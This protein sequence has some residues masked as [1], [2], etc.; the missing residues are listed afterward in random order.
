MPQFYRL[1]HRARAASVS[2][3]TSSAVEMRSR[4]L[5]STALELTFN[6]IYSNQQLSIV[7]SSVVEMCSRLLFSTALEMK[8]VFDCHIERSRDVFAL[9]VLYCARTDNYKIMLNLIQHLSIL[10]DKRLRG[11]PSIKESKTT[12][13]CSN[14][15]NQLKPIY[16]LNHDAACNN[17]NEVREFE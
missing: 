13:L 5:F 1:S 16:S 10:I 17:L 3:V 12:S 11:K 2:I 6:E 4:L 7:T 9:V 14:Y 8:Q 15:A